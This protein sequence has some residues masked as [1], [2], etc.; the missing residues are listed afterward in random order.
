MNES[1]I[2]H[3]AVHAR[4]CYPNES[5]GLYCKKNGEYLYWECENISHKY[6][7]QSFIIEPN[8]WIDCEDTVDEILGIVHSHP[9]GQFK[10]SENDKLSCKHMDIT[11]YLVDPT[12]IRIIKIEP[13]EIDVEKN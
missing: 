6:K 13:D 1:C 2:N 12:N 8:D 7:E 11:F 9:N 4:E 5:C 10:F 3:A